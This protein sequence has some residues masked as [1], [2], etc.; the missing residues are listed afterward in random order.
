MRIKNDEENKKIYIYVSE[1]E[2]NSNKYIQLKNELQNSKNNIIVFIG[3]KTSADKC[4]KEML[5][6]IKI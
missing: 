2:Y 3:G 4:I 5:E 1:E 6:S